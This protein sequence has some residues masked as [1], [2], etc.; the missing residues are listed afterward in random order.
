M[1]LFINYGISRW[2]LLK[3][4]DETP[5]FSIVFKSGAFIQNTFLTKEPTDEQLIL[6]HNAISKLIDYEDRFER[7]NNKTKL[8][9]YCSAFLTLVSLIKVDLLIPVISA[10]LL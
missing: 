9:D 6:A 1:F 3:D 10:T 7:I 5:L 4:I 2:L 8:L